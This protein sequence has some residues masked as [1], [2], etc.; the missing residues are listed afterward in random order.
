MEHDSH[1]VTV[2]YKLSHDATISIIK[3]TTGSNTGDYQ[4]DVDNIGRR[5]SGA[6]RTAPW[7]VAVPSYPGNTTHHQELPHTGHSSSTPQNN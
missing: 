3:Q 6:G 4:K 7:P 2:L 1:D 5:V